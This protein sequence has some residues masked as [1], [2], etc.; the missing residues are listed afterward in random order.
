MQRLEGRVSELEAASVNLP[1]SKGS[2]LN[3]RALETG[4][5]SGDFGDGALRA[6]GFLQ[7][8]WSQN[9]NAEGKG[10]VGIP[11]RRITDCNGTASYDVSTVSEADIMQD[12]ANTKIAL[13][14]AQGALTA[15]RR[16]LGRVREEIAAVRAQSADYLE[17]RDKAWEEVGALMVQ[18]HVLQNRSEVLVNGV[19][20]QE[21]ADALL[22]AAGST[23]LTNGS[24]S[25][26][27]SSSMAPSPQASLEVAATIDGHVG[28][29]ASGAM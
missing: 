16:D 14:E 22:A 21:A 25:D 15:A 29:G 6:F 8:L 28:A 10:G 1:P 24:G 4:E 2:A 18:M 12:L 5:S 17:E 3:S 27:G 26:V 13:A 20:G 23:P 19:G 11:R 7:G 9:M